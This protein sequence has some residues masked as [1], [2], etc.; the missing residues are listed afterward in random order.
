MPILNNPGQRQILTAK[1]SRAQSPKT[2]FPIAMPA[3]NSPGG[4]Q[5][6]ATVSS[7]Y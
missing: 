4:A 5:T 2:M 1:S 6:F 3:L 7:Y